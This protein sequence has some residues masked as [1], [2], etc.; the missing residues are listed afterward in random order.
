MPVHNSE[1]PG[2]MMVVITDL[3]LL[4]TPLTV[5]LIS[6]SNSANAVISAFCF[7]FKYLKRTLTLSS[8]FFQY[9]CVLGEERLSLD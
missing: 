3:L 4:S 7:S 1:T 8:N 5:P 2:I 6:S 9:L